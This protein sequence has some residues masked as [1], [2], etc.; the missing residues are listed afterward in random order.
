[1]VRRTSFTLCVTGAHNMY[2]IAAQVHSS[3]MSDM[4]Q[5]AMVHSPHI[6]QALYKRTHTHSASTLTPNER[7]CQL[8][9]ATT[10]ALRALVAGPDKARDEP[11]VQ[12]QSLPAAAAVDAM[13]SMVSLVAVFKADRH[14]LQRS[15]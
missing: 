6:T 1:M 11:A 7:Q 8:N 4:S 9:Q 15:R 12:H 2:R 3:H 10:V 13:S 14:R 5:A